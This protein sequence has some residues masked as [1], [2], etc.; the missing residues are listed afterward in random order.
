VVWTGEFHVRAPTRIVDLALAPEIPSFFD[1]TQSVERREKLR[2]LH[3]FRDDV[4][5][6]IERDGLVHVNYVPTQVITE[7]LRRAFQTDDGE[8][9]FGLQFASSRDAAGHNVVLFV[10]SMHCVDLKEGTTLAPALE[11]RRLSS[12]PSDEICGQRRSRIGRIARALW[13]A[14]GFKALHEKM[15][16]E[17]Q[18]APRGSSS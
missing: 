2:F 16:I 18:E 4:S 5:K 1:L 13:D 3:E 17:I 15:A 7:Y 8:P 9:V 6:P 14:P 10:D 11:L 12:Q